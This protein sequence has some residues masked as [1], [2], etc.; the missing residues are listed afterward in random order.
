MHVERPVFGKWIAQRVTPE[1][2]ENARGRPF[3]SLGRRGHIDLAGYEGE[4]VQVGVPW[5]WALVEEPSVNSLR[6]PESDELYEK[7]SKWST[8]LYDY[9]TYGLQPNSLQRN[10]AI[11]HIETCLAWEV[12]RQQSPWVDIDEWMEAAKKMV[13]A[14]HGATGATPETRR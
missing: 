5:G 4:R 2:F 9:V 10:S 7:F 13:D 8:L 12:H 14:I 6:G 1:S 3:S 11:R